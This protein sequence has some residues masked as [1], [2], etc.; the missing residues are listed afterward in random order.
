MIYFDNNATTPIDPEVARCLY[1]QSLEGPQNASSQHH[2]GRTSRHRFDAAATRIGVLLGTNLEAVHGSRLIVTSGGTEANQIAL[3]GLVDPSLPLW[4]SRIEHPS[5]LQ[6]A[7]HLQSGGRRVYWIGVDAN[8]VV[9]VDQLQSMMLENLQPSESLASPESLGP[10]VLP[11]RR[12]VRGLLSVM[13]ANNETGVLQPIDR[14]VPLARR[15][16]LV[17]HTDATQWIGKLPFDFDRAAVDAVT[18]SGHKFHAPCGIGGLLLGRGQS[19]RP[20]W[21]GGG[22]QL[23]SRP[24]TEPIALLVAMAEGLEIAHQRMEE[25]ASHMLR[26]RNRFEQQLRAGAPEI[27]IHGAQVPRLANTSLISFPAV[28]R[29]TMF[30]RLDR[31]GLACSTGSACASGSSQPSHVLVAMGAGKDLIE[32]A[33]RFSLSRFSTVSEV[34]QATEL[35]L[36][37]YHKLKAQN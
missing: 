37:S 13:L 35:I 23:G 34:D 16:G 30:M 1:R 20:Q 24:G 4:I 7:E 3:H 33:L 18:F 17:V 9:D 5:I 15:A 26:L 14:I 22:Q 29:Q 19:L 28:D 11:V 25:S 27:V 32:G 31:G 12:V 10:E 8:G 6:L 21:F 2:P 36:A